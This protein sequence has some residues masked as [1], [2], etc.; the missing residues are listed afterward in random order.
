MS[1]YYKIEA[2]SNTATLRIYDAIGDDPLTVSQ[3]TR[4][5]ISQLDGLQGRQITI[6][7]VDPEN[8]TGN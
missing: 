5:L 1:P 8:W 2:R 7:I 4:D 6:Y 3:T